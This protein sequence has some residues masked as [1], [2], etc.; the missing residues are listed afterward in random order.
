MN[1]LHAECDV[2][3]TTKLKFSELKLEIAFAR[4]K[5]A[6]KSETVECNLFLKLKVMM[7]EK[8]LE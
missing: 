8:E 4:L 5:P 7:L 3:L 2:K 6:F 1:K